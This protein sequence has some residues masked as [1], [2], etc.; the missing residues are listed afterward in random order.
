MGQTPHHH[1]NCVQDATAV[2][3]ESSVQELVT[4][5]KT[6]ANLKVGMLLMIPAPQ[7]QMAGK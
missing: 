6:K 1:V 7:K 4:M 5:K 2:K 3:M